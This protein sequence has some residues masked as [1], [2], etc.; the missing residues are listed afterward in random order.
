MSYFKL[1]EEIAQAKDLTEISPKRG[2][3]LV[4]FYGNNRYEFRKFLKRGGESLI[5]LAYDN[6]LSQEIVFKSALPIVMYDHVLGVEHTN[7]EA[8]F[9]HANWQQIREKNPCAARFI[10][11]LLIQQMI[12]KLVRE[13]GA[14]VG[15]VPVVYEFNTTPGLFGVI[16]FIRAEELLDWI[17]NRDKAEILGL[18]D[19]MLKLVAILH[20]YQIIHSD[21][22][23]N[24]WLVLPD[25]RPVL[26][27]F[28]IAKN[29]G[30]KNPL[31]VP[32]TPGMGNPLYSSARQLRYP[33]RRNYQDDIH[34]LAKN[35]HVMWSGHEP[36]LPRYSFLRRSDNEKN[37]PSS[38][39][40]NGLDEIY[41]RAI[42]ETDGER[43]EDIEDFLTDFEKFMATY[44][45][46]QPTKNQGELERRLATLERLAAGVT[47]LLEDL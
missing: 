14:A 12:S 7:E 17:T 24:N 35:L 43:Y 27:D 5:T 25:N 18:F 44:G 39:F 30:V 19:K 26:L 46:P 22:K 40:P 41:F 8:F 42:S 45:P 2:N 47:K 29:L 28:G 16:E 20:H 4:K 34:T 32:G 13:E 6:R 11:G 23:H 31:T 1:L 21:L 3:E 15:Y 37:F 9:S 36:H 33:E 38:I 10:N